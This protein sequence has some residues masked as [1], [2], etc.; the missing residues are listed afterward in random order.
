MSYRIAVLPGDGI[1]IEIDGDSNY[2]VRNVCTDN[3][4][5]YDLAEN[6]RFGAI[7]DHT[8]SVTIPVSG[9]SA[10]SGLGTTDPWANF[11]NTSTP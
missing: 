3:T 11:A 2:I 4:T 5:N 7:V 6:N 10:G 8:I 1:G 9:N